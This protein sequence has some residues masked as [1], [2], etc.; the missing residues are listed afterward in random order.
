VCDIDAGWFM[1]EA[2]T[3]DGTLKTTNWGHWIEFFSDACR[4]QYLLYSS[5]PIQQQLLVGFAARVWQGK[6]GKCCQ[7]QSQTPKTCTPSRGPDPCVGWICQPKMVV[8]RQQLRS[9]ILA[10]Q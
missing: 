6:Y 8:G 4:D 2:A 1:I 3:V 9:P 5:K 7:V 10:A